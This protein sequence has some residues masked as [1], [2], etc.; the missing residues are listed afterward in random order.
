MLY[1][2]CTVSLWD[3]LRLICFHVK[4]QGSYVKM[5]VSVASAVSRP[6]LHLRI[7]IC[8]PY[9]TSKHFVS[10]QRR[11]GCHAVRRR[12][13]GLLAQRPA[14]C[15]DAGEKS[16]SLACGFVFFRFAAAGVEF[17]QQSGRG[18]FMGH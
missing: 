2:Q 12:C 14:L 13:F 16:V 7:S 15:E 11:Y 10:P 8:A 18:R 4:K 17:R 3:H 5:E 1:D 6:G 9:N